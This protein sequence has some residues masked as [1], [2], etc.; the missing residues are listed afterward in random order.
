MF[1]AIYFGQQQDNSIELK[2]K[3]NENT[4]RIKYK[5]DVKLLTKCTI[6]NK[7]DNVHWYKICKKNFKQ[8]DLYQ[9]NRQVLEII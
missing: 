3:M 1:K 8:S 5:E 9:I 2:F 4:E 7:R 6:K